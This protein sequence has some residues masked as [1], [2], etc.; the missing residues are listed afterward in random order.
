M[1][2][3]VLNEFRERWRDADHDV[4]KDDVVR[5]AND[6]NLT[7]S[8]IF[9]EL[10]VELASDFFVGFLGWPFCDGVTN[11]LFDALLQFKEEECPWPNTFFEFYLAFDHSE[12][13]GPQDRELIRSF[14]GQHKTLFG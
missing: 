9:D 6:A 13:E 8:K 10:A 11:A 3:A 2:Q 14:L 4:G 1:Y 5:W 12:I 7:P